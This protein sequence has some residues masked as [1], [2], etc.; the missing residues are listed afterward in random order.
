M[1]L[2]QPDPGDLQL[3]PAYAAGIRARGW[4]TAFLLQW[5]NGW[6]AFLSRELI[7]LAW[8][9]FPSRLRP[10]HGNA[11]SG[12]QLLSPPTELYAP[13]LIMNARPR[14]RIAPSLTWM[15]WSDF[16]GRHEAAAHGRATR[17]R[18]SESGPMAWRLRREARASKQLGIARIYCR[19]SMRAE[20]PVSPVGELQLVFNS[21]IRVACMHVFV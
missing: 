18:G 17:R 4:L 21:E 6:C 14:A 3:R 1:Q 10:G 19:P 20:R 5:A 8:S 2:P 16:R 15:N 7:E 13:S 12:V 11:S 9:S